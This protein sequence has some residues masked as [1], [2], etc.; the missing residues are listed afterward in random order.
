MDD[1]LLRRVAE[2]V[3]TQGR[4]LDPEQP[5]VRLSGGLSNLNFRVRVDGRD[6]VLR[7]PPAGKLPPGA[8][9]MVREHRLLSRLAKVF[10]QAPESFLLC[11]DLSVLGVPFQL[12]E[13]RT[14]TVIQGDTLPPALSAPADRKAVGLRLV[15]T[16]AALHAVDADAAGLGDFGRPAGFYARTVDGWLRRGRD[17]AGDNDD[18]ARRLSAIGSWLVAEAPRDAA[19]VILH[20]DFK[21]DNCMLD[22]DWNVTTVL[23]WDMGTRGHPLMDIATLASY[24]TEPGDPDCMHRLAQMPTAAAGFPGRAEAVEH[25]AR[26]S[27]RD[28]SD[29]PAWRVLAL[30]KLGVVFLQLHRNW[31][32]G[33]IGNETYAGFA[34]LVADILD[35]AHQQTGS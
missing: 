30:L 7:R 18:L 17:V 9:D 24:W 35:Y 25:Y 22:G 31:A 4:S 1:A 11:E 27:G 19:P 14:G 28:V 10:P 12:I 6:A 8:H 5:A 20:S 16:L 13:Y 33:A 3:A 29:F 26:V 34:A 23:D 21:L 15:E 32:S 2:H